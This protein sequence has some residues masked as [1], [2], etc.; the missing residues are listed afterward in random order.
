MDRRIT[1]M[2]KQ[3]ERC[4]MRTRLISLI[5]GIAVLFGSQPATADGEHFELMRASGTIRIATNPGIEP[6][7]F[8]RGDQ[9]VGYDIDFGAEQKPVPFARG[10]I[11]RR[12]YGDGRS[13]YPCNML[14]RN[15][16]DSRRL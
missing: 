2:Q 9:L 3:I 6:M 15:L 12:S 13:D 14:D 4:V 8:L 7:E 16:F 1:K 11:G 10:Y 5:L